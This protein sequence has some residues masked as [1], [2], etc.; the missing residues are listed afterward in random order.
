M[1]VP[2]TA[3]VL[4]A[5]ITLW[6]CALIVGVSVHVHNTLDDDSLAADARSS[7][8]EQTS[9]ATS[10]SASQAPIPL[11][12]NYT[13]Q[14]AALVADDAGR[15][16]AKDGV[17]NGSAW[18]AITGCCMDDGGALDVSLS[19]V[20]CVANVNSSNDLFA[21]F[22]A[23]GGCCELYEACVACCVRASLLVSAASSRFAWCAIK[24]RTS[25]ESLDYTGR[26]ISTRIYCTR[27]IA[28][29]PASPSRT[30]RPSI[31]AAGASR[32]GTS[33]S[34]QPT[35]EML[36]WRKRLLRG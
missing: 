5:V 31:A 1:K 17:G 18:D 4:G 6:V 28:S 3:I 13:T 10:P 14:S 30:L 32:L 27:R 22:A 25:S 34:P 12:C 36:E 20:G 23:S 26:Y 15:L 16:C 11:L 29:A 8:D 9:S 33:P 35:L 2:T 19:C 24:C 21:D 7:Q